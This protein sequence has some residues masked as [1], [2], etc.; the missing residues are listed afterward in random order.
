MDNI[1]KPVVELEIAEMLPIKEAVE[2][3][4]TMND[5]EKVESKD[6]LPTLKD[7]VDTIVNDE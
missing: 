7:V 4:K 1:L 5:D 2:V 3:I 6:E